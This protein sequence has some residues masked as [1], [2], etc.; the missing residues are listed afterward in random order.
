MRALKLAVTDMKKDDVHVVPEHENYSSFILLRH[1]N[2][3]ETHSYKKKKSVMS[4]LTREKAKKHSFLCFYMQ[5]FVALHHT[6]SVAALL[7]KFYAGVVISRT[8][9]SP[10]RNFFVMLKVA[11]HA[12]TVPDRTL[13]CSL[14]FSSFAYSLLIRELSEAFAFFR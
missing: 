13:A 4:V 2:S 11:I 7:N 1:K 9:Q 8:Y 5:I 3:F 14:R 12:L 10:H 6:F